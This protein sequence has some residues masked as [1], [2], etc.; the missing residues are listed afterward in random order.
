[1]TER[2][3]SL[4]NA[5]S[6]G[7]LS[8]F[9]TS[10][11]DRYSLYEV[12]NNAE[13][14]LKVGL[15]YNSKKIIVNETSAFP[16]KGIIRVG[17]PSGTQGDSELIYYD[18]KTTNT[19]YNLVR[20]FSGSTQNQWPSGSF[21]TNAVVAE[22]HNAVK[23]AIINVQ[24]FIGLKDNPDQN[25]LNRRLKDLELKFLS[26]KASFRAFPRK[27]RPNTTIKFQNFSEGDVVRYVW[28]FGDGTTS[29]LPNPE[30]AYANEG[31]Y[32]IKL[33]LITSTGAQGISTKDNYIT[34]SSDERIAFFYV[35]KIGDKKYRFIDQTDGDIKQR[36]WVF[37]GEGTIKNQSNIVQNY[38]END[39][40]NHEVV[41]EYSE[42]GTYEPSLLINFASD[43]I[44]RIFLS[45]KT[46]EVA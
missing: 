16:E 28:E 19:F 29:V 13:T 6:V 8:L 31:T 41:F 22:P 45:G 44:K 25:T 42:K 24:H 1:M 9:P 32:T 23:D 46:L 35:K 11:D 10:L 27:T 20:G 43:K 12:A 14:K 33:H 36:F 15:G 4:D 21:V 39:P 40:N 34:V 26:P 17:P 30:H 37:G 3:S 18:S 2:V 7:N 5:Y 38:V